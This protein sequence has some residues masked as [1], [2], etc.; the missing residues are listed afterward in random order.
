MWARLLVGRYK[1]RDGDAD[2]AALHFQRAAADAPSE[3]RAWEGL[4]LTY[5]RQGRL[6]AAAGCT[7]Q[8]LELRTAPPAA[9]TAD[10]PL[11][12]AGEAPR[13][14]AAA[15]A[16]A[17]GG[18]VSAEAAAAARAAEAVR[19]R[20]RLAS[21]LLRLGETTEAAAEF[22]AA[23]AAA[24][25]P[26]A[27]VP[28][29][30]G[31]ARARLA[32][33][34]TAA[35]QGFDARALRLFDGAVAALRGCVREPSPPVVARQL[36]A[37]ALAQR[38]A[39]APDEGKDDASLPARRAVA[40]LV[41][42][43]PTA[44]VGWELLASGGDAPAAA[45]DDTSSAVAAERAALLSC[46]DGDGAAAAEPADVRARLARAVALDASAVPPLR[47]F[48]LAAAAVGARQT[49]YASAAAVLRREP[50]DATMLEVQAAHLEAWGSL[51][52]SA[53]KLLAACA[54]ASDDNDAL[55]RIFVA[56]ARVE[57]RRGNWAPAS[58]IAAEARRAGVGD[59]DAQLSEL[60]RAIAAGRRR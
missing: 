8:L 14:G 22:D 6:R 13:A 60:E 36:L 28:A 25:T 3:A 59:D 53:E 27:A 58:T 39:L 47:Q 23:A 43:D 11:G 10:P 5:E 15:A 18:G 54:A 2:G 48:S 46:F 1:L 35:R 44:K 57:C 41:H 12:A 29:L 56:W 19:D 55:R 42:A 7:R 45:A 31:G 49:S 16:A 50:H 26:A 32:E 51:N 38:A 40:A 9:P 17:L 52:Q 4:A 37:T 30:V 21:L 24:A 34:R 20:C 33:A